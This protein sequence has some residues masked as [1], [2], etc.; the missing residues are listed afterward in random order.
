MRMEWLRSRIVRLSAT[1]PIGPARSNTG[2]LTIERSIVDNNEAQVGA[3][4]VSLNGDVHI[5]QS[6]F[7][8]NAAAP[9]GFGGLW[10]ASGTGSVSETTFAFNSSDGSGGGIAV[11][12]S[13]SLKVSNSAFIGNFGNDAGSAIFN[14]GTG[15]GG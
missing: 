9:A 3:G 6:R 14:L 7:T 10:L 12:S 8:R 11:S 15:P 1:A 4:L 2:A 5:S 13:A